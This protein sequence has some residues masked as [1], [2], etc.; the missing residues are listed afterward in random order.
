MSTQAGIETGTATEKCWICRVDDATTGEHTIKKTDLEAI[1]GNTL[2]QGKLFLHT[3]QRTNQQVQSLRSDSLKAKARLCEH[4]NSARTQ[5]YDRAWTLISTWLRD[6]QQ[7]FRLYGYLRGN[8]VFPN[9]TSAQMLD[10]HLYFVK[11]FGCRIK[12]EQSEIE[13]PLDQFSSTLMERKA[14]PGVYLQVGIGNGDVG[15]GPLRRERMPSGHVRAI[16][17]YRIADFAVSVMYLDPGTTWDNTSGAWHPKFG[18]NRLQLKDFTRPKK[19]EW[20]E[21][22]GEGAVHI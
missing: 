22:D 13:I 21:I 11:L 12:A 10:A 7:P 15:W 20:A 19:G 8:R 5:P 14:H 1:F 4:C 18:T 16:W 3:L 2:S 6:R 9:F 17:L